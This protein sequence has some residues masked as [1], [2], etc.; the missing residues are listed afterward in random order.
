MWHPFQQV[1]EVLEK[2]PHV[3]L[4]N[5]SAQ[6]TFLAPKTE[7]VKTQFHWPKEQ[8]PRGFAS[9]Q[10]ITDASL[11]DAPVIDGCLTAPASTSRPCAHDPAKLATLRECVAAL[12]V[13]ILREY[14]KKEELIFTFNDVHHR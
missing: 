7:T 2:N 9:P 12:G 8:K 14:G 3:H 13:D 1:V 11:M 6:A 5:P 10:A 4:G